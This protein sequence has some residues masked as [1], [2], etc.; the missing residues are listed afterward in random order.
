ML[1]EPAG[2]LEWSLVY[3]FR[4]PDVSRFEDLR[5]R[6]APVAAIST[7]TRGELQTSARFRE[8]IAP[9]GAK[10]ELRIALADPFGLWAALVIFTAR[11]M[12]AEDLTFVA[13]LVP[14]ATAALRRAAVAAAIECRPRGGAPAVEDG[15]PS[16]LIL[17]RDDRIITA[18]ASAR[19]RLAMVPEPRP[20]ELPGLI[21]FV[22]AQ[23]RWSSGGRSATARMRTDGGQWLLVNASV[24]DDGGAG[25]VAVVMQ[26]APAAAVLDTALRAYG[27]TGRE[28]EVAALVLRGHS[29]KAIASSLVI[30]PWTVQDHMKAIY[31]KTGL[32]SRAELVALRP[33]AL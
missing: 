2:T 18:D 19:R 5:A 10:D 28:R 7:E 32:R 21:S 30:S 16:V 3:E 9:A 6:R 17:N 25:D 23:A 15:G 13:A 27:L 4:R 11:R 31:E 12:T 26:P 8:M 33:S 14:A 29:A 1:G 20:V 22:S 24:L